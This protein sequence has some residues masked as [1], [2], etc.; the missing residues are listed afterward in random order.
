MLNR[1]IPSTTRPP[2]LE[3]Q[4]LQAHHGGHDQNGR[5]RSE[6][7]GGQGTSYEVA[8]CAAGDGEVDHLRGKYECAQHAHHRDHALAEV[9]ARSGARQRRSPARPPRIPQ[10]PQGRLKKPSG[11]CSGSHDSQ[12]NTL[13]SML[14]CTGSPPRR[15]L[16]AT[17]SAGLP[18]VPAM[19]K[20]R[21]VVEI[22][23]EAVCLSGCR[24]P[25]DW[26]I[27]S[28]SSSTPSHPWHT[29]WWCRTWSIHSYECWSAAHVGF[30]NQPHLLQHVKRAVHGGE[31]D[32]GVTLLDLFEHFSRRHVARRVPQRG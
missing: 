28:S 29:R 7:D 25:S 32:E 20:D 21:Q 6:D 12:F 5:P 30:R 26:S 3:Q 16:A 1:L 10:W 23:F 31:V 15:G 18:A 11:A 8:G 9:A 27:S 4:R 13:T 14:S 22:H 17:L 24:A 19:A 2:S